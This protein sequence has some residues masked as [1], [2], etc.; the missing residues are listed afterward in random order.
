MWK[1]YLQQKSF[2]GVKINDNKGKDN[3]N[4][5]KLNAHYSRSGGAKDLAR[6]FHENNEGGTIINTGTS[7]KREGTI[8]GRE[9]RLR[10]GKILMQKVEQDPVL[11]W[12]K[13]RKLL[14]KAKHPCTLQTQGSRPCSTT[15]A[16]M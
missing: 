5:G 10:V 3:L 16:P 15:L 7:Q 12:R 9:Q 8:I 2:S 14:T 13:I 4:S 1:V 11:L 6:G